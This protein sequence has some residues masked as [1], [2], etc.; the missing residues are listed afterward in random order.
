MVSSLTRGQIIKRK[1]ILDS[2]ILRLLEKIKISIFNNLRT[3][4][5]DLKVCSKI[6]KFDPSGITTQKCYKNAKK[7]GNNI[8]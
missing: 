5:E 6:D 4:Y 3:S 7:I 8:Y 2:P 1:F